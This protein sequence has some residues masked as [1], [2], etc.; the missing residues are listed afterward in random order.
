ME[1]HRLSGSSLY[2][3][4]RNENG[5]YMVYLYPNAESY[6]RSRQPGD[7][8]LTTKKQAHSVQKKLNTRGSEPY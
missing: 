2:V 3:V 6:A 7:S 5:R 4:R 8:V 1:R